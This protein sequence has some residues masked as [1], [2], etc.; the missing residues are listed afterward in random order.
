MYAL[1][2]RKNRYSPWNDVCI[3]RGGTAD[4]VR[5]FFIDNYCWE[6]E[7]EFEIRDVDYVGKSTMIINNAIVDTGRRIYDFD[8]LLT[9]EAEVHRKMESL[10]RVTDL[11]T[12]LTERER[13]LKREIEEAR[14]DPL[15]KFSVTKRRRQNGD[16]KIDDHIAM[17]LN[18]PA[19]LPMVKCPCCNEDVRERE[20]HFSTVDFYDPWMCRESIR[21]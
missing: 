14:C 18:L 7:D 8:Q 15:L 16:N 9:E 1:Y 21:K 10:S 12:Q 6:A 5:Q 19:K 11:K 20:Q 17:K 4:T 2:Y 13:L 3:V